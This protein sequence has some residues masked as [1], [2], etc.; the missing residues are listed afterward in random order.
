MI[1]LVAFIGWFQPLV[2]VTMR[3]G[4]QR[5]KLARDAVARRYFVETGMVELL[6][7]SMGERASKATG[8]SLFVGK[9]T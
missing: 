2:I 7:G 1:V 5:S 9:R 3:I 8:T 4:A 6:S